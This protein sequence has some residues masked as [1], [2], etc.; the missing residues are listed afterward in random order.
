MIFQRLKTKNVK[1]VSKGAKIR[2]RY[3]QVPHLTQDTNGKVTNSQ[4]DTTNESQEVSPFPAGD[5][6]AHINRRPQRH[7]KHKTEQK[8]KRSR[9][10]IFWWYW[11]P[12]LPSGSAHDILTSFCFPFKGHH[13]HKLYYKVIS[14]QVSFPQK[15]EY[16]NRKDTINSVTKQGHSMK[17]LGDDTTFA[18]SLFLVAPIVMGEVRNRDI[19]N[20]VPPPK[21]LIKDSGHRKQRLLCILQTKC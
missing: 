6:K 20:V 12:C 21:V 2:S 8:H 11:T 7:S 19:A 18:I 10:P 1:K 9:N 14:N 3:N 5:H 15:I 17:P 13:V 16:Q 4:L